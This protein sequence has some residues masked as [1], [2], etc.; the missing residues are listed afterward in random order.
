MRSLLQKAA[1]AARAEH[2]PSDAVC[3]QKIQYEAN[4]VQPQNRKEVSQVEEEAALANFGGR[5]R[6]R[7]ESTKTYTSCAATTATTMVQTTA[8]SL[9]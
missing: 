1:D 9:T 5:L 7:K 4:T 6:T 2:E 8:R 3:S